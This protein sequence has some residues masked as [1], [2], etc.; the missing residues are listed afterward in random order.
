MS[1]IKVLLVIFRPRPTG[2]LQKLF[3]VAEYPCL[4][5]MGDSIQYEDGWSLAS[6]RYVYLSMIPSLPEIGVDVQLTDGEYESLKFGG[7]WTEEFPE[8]ARV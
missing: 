3:R 7:N 5:R 1:Q 4:P 2:P 8:A 6:V